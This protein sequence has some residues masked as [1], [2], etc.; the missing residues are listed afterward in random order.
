MIYDPI[1]YIQRISKEIHMAQ[2]NIFTSLHR[3]GSQEY[4][5]WSKFI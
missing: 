4:K 2:N 1:N 5:I 3:M